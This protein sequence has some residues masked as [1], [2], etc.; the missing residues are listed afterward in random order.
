MKINLRSSGSFL[1]IKKPQ[2]ISMEKHNNNIKKV[3]LQKETL[4]ISIKNN[5]VNSIIQNNTNSK[6]E[7]INILKERISILEKKVQFLENENI[8][9]NNSNN[10]KP[11]FFNFSH[12]NTPKNLPNLNF[13][14]KYFKNKQ[15]FLNVFAPMKSYKRRSKTNFNN[16]TTK[17]NY[18]YNFSNIHISSNSNKSKNTHSTAVPKILKQKL[19]LMNSKK[20]SL[21]KSSTIDNVKFST[22][23]RSI[24]N[25][26]IN[27]SNKSSNN[28]PKIPKRKL[29]RLKSALYSNNISEK[30]L[31]RNLSCKNM[32]GKSNNNTDS[33]C[34]KIKNT[35]FSEVKNKMDNIKKRTENLLKFYANNYK[36]N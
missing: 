28:I 32:S 33:N 23:E 18:N 25:D 15:N 1:S 3:K 5:P 35:S 31:I 21:I 24:S 22:I 9:N 20:R 10:N 17:F 29:F 7:I 19:I 14:I 13:N 27:K 8:N 36:N 11:I 6:D 2:L 26:S 34:Q 12:S 4:N 30:N 16:H